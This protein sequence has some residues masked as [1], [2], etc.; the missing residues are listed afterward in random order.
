MRIASLSVVLAVLVGCTQNDDPNTAAYWLDHLGNKHER[1][2][3]LKQLGRIGDKSALPTVLKWF[4]EPGEWQ[5]DAAY[6]LGQLGDASVVPVLVASIDANAGAGKDATSRHKN[7][8]NISIV[9]ALAMLGAK[10]TAPEIKKLLRASDDKVREAALTALGE[11]GD[12][13]NADVL[14]EAALDEKDPL[15]RL[16]AIQA[17]GTLGSVKGVPALVQLL[18]IEKPVSFYADARYAL[19]QIGA[20]AVPELVKTLEGNNAEVANIKLPDGS[21][22][23]EGIVEAK[24][25]STLG[26]LRAV[27]AEVPLAQALGRLYERAKKPSATPFV[28]ASVVELAYA[29][30]NL[31]QPGAATALLPLVR[32]TDPNVRLAACEALITTGNREVVPQLLAAAK[33]GN[34]AAR[35]AAIVAVSR[36]GTADSLAAYDALGKAGDPKAPAEQMAKLVAAE[37]SRLVAAKECN[38]EVACWQKKLADG[39]AKVRERA[40]YEL[41][42]LGAKTAGPNL[43]KA[44]EDDDPEVRMAAVLSLGRVGGADTKQLKEILDRWKSKLEYRVVNDELSRLIAR[45]KSKK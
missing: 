24:A 1:G 30:G 20:P 41:G 39:D 42:W 15:V 17:L 37:R 27:S 18:Y 21:P 13:K 7:R 45:T 11:L 32:D 36:L 16:A 3:A 38:T 5:A 43:L 26:A 40:A 23:P 19:V 4:K 34:L 2:E 35:R 12:D 8:T 33:T 10:D 14:T 6:S 29:L 9:R 25:G 28:Q 31:G 44:A 22:L